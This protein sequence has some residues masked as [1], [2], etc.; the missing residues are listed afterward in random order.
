MVAYSL[1]AGE[2]SA[3]YLVLHSAE[4]EELMGGEWSMN[5]WGDK[6]K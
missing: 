1:N 6:N 3:L 5:E 2:F 4:W